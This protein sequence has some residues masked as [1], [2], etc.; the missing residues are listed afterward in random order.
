MGESAGAAAVAVVESKSTDMSPS[1]LNQAPSQ[2]HHIQQVQNAQKIK[3]V[4]KVNHNGNNNRKVFEVILLQIK[5]TH[6]QSKLAKAQMRSAQPCALSTGR[7]FCLAETHRRSGCKVSHLSQAPN[8]STEALW[9]VYGTLV[10]SGQR[11]GV[12][13]YVFCHRDRS[14]ALYG[15]LQWLVFVPSC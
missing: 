14:D 1:V 11:P 15:P 8:P 9:A 2:I 12:W 5:I 3:N 6:G 4:D 10:T 13:R 7:A